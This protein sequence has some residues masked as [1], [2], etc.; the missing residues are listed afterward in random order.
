MGLNFSDPL[1]IYTYNL[2]NMGSILDID[3]SLN[4]SNE[5]FEKY[6]SIGNAFKLTSIRN[7]EFVKNRP[8]PKPFHDTW[9]DLIFDVDRVC[10]TETNT[11][12]FGEKRLFEE[13]GHALGIDAPS[14]SPIHKLFLAKLLN[15]IYENNSVV[16]KLNECKS[17]D[18]AL[19][20]ECGF[21]M[22]GA[23]V[24]LDID[25]A[26]MSFQK[27]KR[28]ELFSK[29]VKI[30][31]DADFDKNIRLLTLHIP[32]MFNNG[33]YVHEGELEFLFIKRSEPLFNI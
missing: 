16:H 31:F 26:I 17:R 29:V 1:I 4:T 7:V 19:D 8:V 32:Y 11:A 3:S 18:Y 30:V 25:E 28:G 33:N 13:L 5:A 10:Y 15:A 12:M 21:F 9:L 20:P 14:F 22:E 2:L 23:I 24:D 6:Y 27:R